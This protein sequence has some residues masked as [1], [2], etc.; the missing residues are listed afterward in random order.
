MVHLLATILIPLA[1]AGLVFAARGRTARFAVLLATTVAHLFATIAL[2][3]R[4][5]I[6]T[7]AGLLGLDA[8]G[9]LFLT[10]ISVLYCLVAV[11]LVAYTKHETRGAPPIF[12]ACHLFSLAA[13]T[14]A[15]LS[16]HWGLF[17]VA[18]EATT[19]A[20][21]PLL[22]FNHNAR[23]LEATWKYLLIG[24]VGIGLALFG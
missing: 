16:S 19:L 8:A 24:S 11:Q 23:S 5:P 13:M 3:P 17:W 21:A 9:L 22:Y 2:W 10:V 4:E 6:T 12:L 18:M 1:G 20:S 14:I 7:D 15:T